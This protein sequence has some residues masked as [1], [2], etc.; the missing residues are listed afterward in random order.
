MTMLGLRDGK[1]DGTSFIDLAEIID[2]IS[3]NPSE[4]LTE[5]F[6]RVVFD[7]AVSNQDDHLRNHGFLL[8]ERGWRLSPAY[9]INPVNNARHL[10]LYIDMDDGIRSFEKALSTCEFYHLGIEAAK[11]IIGRTAETVAG[12]WQKLADRYEIKKAEQRYMA[13]AFEM[14]KEYKAL[15]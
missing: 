10:S 13:S 12:T 5:L 15:P 6:R 4:D 1:T 9:D 2:R 14:A 3:C 7:I 8:T 11:E